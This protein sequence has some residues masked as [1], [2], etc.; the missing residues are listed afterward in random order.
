MPPDAKRSLLAEHL[1]EFRSWSYDTLV[2]EIDRSRKTHDCLRHT[3]GVF[4]D[5]TEYQMEFNVFWDDKRGGDVRVCGDISTE[6]Q[7]R[8]LWVLPIYIPD[9]TD[10]F[11]MAQDGSFVGD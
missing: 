3:E 5:G 1:A 10:S 2:A 8:L 6:P 9:A 4:D 11:I 7:R